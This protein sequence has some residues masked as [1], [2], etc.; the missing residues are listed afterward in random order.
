VLSNSELLQTDKANTSTKLEST[1][2]TNLPLNQYRNLRFGPLRAPSDRSAKGP[3][4]LARALDRQPTAA[5][6]SDATPLVRFLQSDRSPRGETESRGTVIQVTSSPPVMVTG[7][8]SHPFS[9]L[10]RGAAR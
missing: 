10:S 8:H 4:P 9:H 2:V 3:V 5:I 6:G 7:G 1:A